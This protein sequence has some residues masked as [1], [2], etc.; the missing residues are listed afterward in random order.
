M[1][2]I[3]KTL[4]AH[5]RYRQLFE[6]GCYLPVR[7]VGCYKENVIAF[8]RT[9]RE[10]AAIIVTPR[11][12]TSIV[13]PAQPP[14]GEKLWKDTRIVTP[15]SSKRLWRNVITEEEVKGP[16]EIFIGHILNKCP[17]GLI[18]TEKSN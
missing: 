2:L 15:G 8:A 3:Y 1:F 13:G 10:K 12:V 7:V 9:L 4:S 14:I 18:I 6:N 11:F 5:K 17:V 16:K